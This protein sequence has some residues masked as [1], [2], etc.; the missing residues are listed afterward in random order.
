MTKS[1]GEGEYYRQQ[2]LECAAAAGATPRP[3]VKEA[4]LNLT[5]AWLQ[6]AP[7]AIDSQ[8]TLTKQQ[9][10]KRASRTVRA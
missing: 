3:E 10:R 2:A 5:Q 4:Y 7:N 1:V 8:Y 9:S 6:L